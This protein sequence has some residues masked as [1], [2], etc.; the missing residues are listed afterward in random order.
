[1][2]EPVRKLAAWVPYTSQVDTLHGRPIHEQLVDLREGVQRTLLSITDPWLF[3]DGWRG[4]PVTFVLDEPT[5]RVERWLERV[6]DRL[7][8]GLR[9][10]TDAWAVLTGSA[11]IDDERED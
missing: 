11:T 1:M 7:A 9:R 2:K 3:P 4:W 8:V 6:V 5:D 10:V